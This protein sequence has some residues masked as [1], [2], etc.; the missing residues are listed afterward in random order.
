[1]SKFGPKVAELFTKAFEW[2]KANWEIALPIIIVVVGV[3]YAFTFCSTAKYVEWEQKEAELVRRIGAEQEKLNKALAELQTEPSYMFEG[4]SGGVDWQAA[5]AS[6]AAKGKEVIG[7]LFTWGK[8]KWNERRKRQLQLAVKNARES[9]ATLEGELKAH[10]EGI[11]HMACQMR[12]IAMLKFESSAAAAFKKFK[13][14]VEEIDS[15]IPSE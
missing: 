5:A 1:M 13:S 4:E 2:T 14:T 11:K 6:T 9:I 7:Q 15:L 3:I 12:R 8:E 10:T